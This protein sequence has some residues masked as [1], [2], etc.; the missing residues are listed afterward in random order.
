M[1]RPMSA[2]SGG[3]E[4][5]QEN[6]GKLPTFLAPLSQGK[7]IESDTVL[8]QSWWWFLPLIA[9]LTIEWIVRKRVGML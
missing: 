1:L 8:W 2:A 7:V 3:Q 9:L 6:I 5:A 4:L